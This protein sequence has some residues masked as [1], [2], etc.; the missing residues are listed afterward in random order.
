MEAFI[1]EQ[2]TKRPRGSYRT[3]QGRKKDMGYWGVGEGG[4]MPGVD[5]PDEV[6]SRS[7]SPTVQDNY[8]GMQ[9]DGVSIVNEDEVEGKKHAIHG[10]VSLDGHDGAEAH[11]FRGF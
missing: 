6:V 1:G 11:H 5:L 9:V 10:D 7:R 8:Q 3:R 4:I 2:G